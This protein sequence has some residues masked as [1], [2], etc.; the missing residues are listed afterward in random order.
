MVRS[1]ADTDT[2]LAAKH[3]ALVTG[4]AGNLGRYRVP[5]L[6]RQA[7]VIALECWIDSDAVNAVNLSAEDSVASTLHAVRDAAGPRFARVEHLLRPLASV[8]PV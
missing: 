4:A 8:R 1:D 7:Q 5:G 6:H 3:I 2:T